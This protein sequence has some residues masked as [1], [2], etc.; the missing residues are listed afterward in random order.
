MSVQAFAVLVVA[1]LLIGVAAQ[2]VFGDARKAGCAAML[3]AAAAVVV[4]VIAGDP[5]GAWTWL[6]SLLVMPLPVALALTAVLLCHGR[7]RVRHK[8]HR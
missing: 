3:G 1:P 6:A 5:G 4:G 2:L 7:S 8:H